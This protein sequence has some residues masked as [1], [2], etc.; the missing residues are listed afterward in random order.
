ML[1][2]RDVGIDTPLHDAIDAFLIACDASNKSERTKRWYRMNLGDFA[3]WL[4]TNAKPLTLAS[5]DLKVGFRV[6]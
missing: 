4:A 1:R 3:E 2:W 5:L 6:N